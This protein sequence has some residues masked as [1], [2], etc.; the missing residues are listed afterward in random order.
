VHS[1]TSLSTHSPLTPAP[2]EGLDEVPKHTLDP[3]RGKLHRTLG[4]LNSLTKHDSARLG[5][6]INER[7]AKRAQELLARGCV[8]GAARGP[9]AWL[10]TVK[11]AWSATSASRD[12]R[13]RSTIQGSGVSKSVAQAALPTFTS[14]KRDA[15]RLGSSWD[16]RREIELREQ[17]V[18]FCQAPPNDV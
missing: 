17:R 10:P 16:D 14:P 6:G 5:G 12:S 3:S 4:K 13:H 1:L 8:L 2:P 11:V 18:E 9:L 15:R 7:G